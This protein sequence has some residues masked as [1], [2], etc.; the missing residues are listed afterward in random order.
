MS[1]K[2]SGTAKSWTVRTAVPLSVGF[3]TLGV[4]WVG[5][6][7]IYQSDFPPLPG[8]GCTLTCEENYELQGTGF[9]KCMAGTLYDWSDAPGD[10][11]AGE[12]S[13]N[14]AADQAES[15]SASACLGVPC[16]AAGLDEG[17]LS[18]SFSDSRLY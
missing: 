8:E 4:K 11:T 17:L 13:P 3:R 2:R 9:F 14:T 1:G 16:A 6:R 10:W 7:D 5:Q 12:W 18:F 15:P